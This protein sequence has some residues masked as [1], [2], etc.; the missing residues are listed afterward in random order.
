MIAL[1]S[2]IAII[3]FITVVPLTLA[4]LSKLFIDLLSDLRAESMGIV[5]APTFK[6]KAEHAFAFGLHLLIPFMLIGSAII[7]VTKP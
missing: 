2:I 3:V 5:G 4:I 6:G 7:L 1:L